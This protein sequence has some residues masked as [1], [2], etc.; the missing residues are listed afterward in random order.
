MAKHHYTFVIFSN[1]RDAVKKIC[2]SAKFL[3]SVSACAA[4][5]VAFM[6][7]VLF[8]YVKTKKE[9]ME[10]NNV[11]RLAE[12]QKD[13][14]NSLAGKVMDFERKLEYFRQMEQK[15]RSTGD[16]VKKTGAKNQFLGVG[17]IQQGEQPVNPSIDNLHRNMDRLISDAEAQQR[18]F[19]EVLEF[20]KKRQS[21]LASLP[22]LW[23]VRGWVT[24]NFGYRQSPYRGQSSEFHKGIDIATR[25]GNPV[26]APAD[27]IVAENVNRPDMGNYIIINH[28]NGVSTSYAHLLRSAV[29]H[30]QNVKKGDVIGYVGNS[31]RSTGSHLHYSVML[32][33][34][35]VNPRK[36]LN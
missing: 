16:I 30:G 11:K 8:D 12:I 36:Y 18:N 24:S 32:N 7:F 34:V 29:H 13:Q 33:G 19:E 6:A 26:V 20:L 1:K 2:A 9:G 28:K 21:V 35:P 17:G 25:A 23:P 4:L 14:I 5:L 3:K 10:F 22:S 15:I 27:G 31:G